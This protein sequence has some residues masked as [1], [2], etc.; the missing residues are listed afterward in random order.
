MSF[1]IS[2]LVYHLLVYTKMILP[3]SSDVTYD[4]EGTTSAATVDPYL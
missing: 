2:M 3:G 1:P 4:A